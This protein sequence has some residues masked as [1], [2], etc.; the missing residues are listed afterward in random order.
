MRCWLTSI[1][2]LAACGA[3]ADAPP[4]AIHLGQVV[5]ESGE[6]MAE[7]EIEIDGAMSLP[8]ELDGEARVVEV[9]VASADSVCAALDGV[10]AD[11][12]GDAWFRPRP[13]A[14][15][16]AELGLEGSGRARVRVWARGAPVPAMRRERSLVWTD[17]A[18]VE[19]PSLVGPARVLAAASD[20]G[21]GGR[22]LAAWLQRFATTSHSERAGPALFEEAL[23]ERL[24]PDPATW[25]L[26]QLPFVVTGVHN[27]LDLAERSGGCGELRVSLAS[28][29]P[30][31][32]PFHLLFLFQQPARDDDVAPDGTI[33][34]LGTA[35]RWARLAALDGADML[36]AVR[37]WLDEVVTHDH[38]L[39]AES[40][41]LT[42]SPWE[43]RQ[44]IPTG[45]ALDNPPLF[46]TIDVEALDQPG[47]ARDDFL[48][49]ATDNA[50]AL[51]ARRAPIPDR[52]RPRSAR[53][54]PTGD[55][56]TLDLTG[57][58]PAILSQYPTL[59]ADIEIAGCPACHTTDD[60]FVQTSVMREFS[61]LYDRELTARGARLDQLNRGEVPD[62]VP[63][64]PLSN[65]PRRRE[66]HEELILGMPRSIVA[67]PQKS[68]RLRV[69]AVQK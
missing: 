2:L 21:H 6:G 67:Y 27:R 45:G 29:D 17:P 48:A 23:E 18:V 10:A 40:V 65:Q 52:F 33:H 43:W 12:C 58:D 28:I 26:D 14:A 60:Q 49:W 55:R 15:A 44:W 16:R 25:D 61:P 57:L 13:V 34:C 53:V 64:G 32:A 69:F 3:G 41:E 24:G 31:Y 62:P 5:D 11:S 68:S 19:D 36:A 39:L 8:I 37:A 1:V 47:P 63:F 42:V 38:F 46:Q 22:M 50:E 7:M 59:A 54:P 35:R 51:A 20:D 30:I 66:G 56:V 4:D 9:D